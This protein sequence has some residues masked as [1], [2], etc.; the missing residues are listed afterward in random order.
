[1]RAMIFGTGSI[2]RRHVASLRAIDPGAEFLI[3]RRSGE[4]DDFSRRLGAQVVRTAVEGIDAGIDLAV[5]ATPSDL[6]F[7]PL[8]AA[9]AAGIPTFVEK[10]VVISHGDLDVLERVAET[11]LVP[12]QVGCVLRFLP[13]SSVLKQWLDEGRAGKVVRATFDVGQYLPDWRPHQDYRTSY[14]ADSKRGGGVIFDLVHELDLAVYLFGD[15]RLAAAIA[16][17]NSR[18]ELA[19]EDTAL[20]ALRAQD[21]ILVSVALDYVSR[22]PTRSIRI[23]GD[24]ATLSLDFIRCRLE[25]ITAG[26]ITDAITYGFETDLAYQAELMDLIAAIRAG[27]AT[28]LPLRE[29]LRSTRL[30]IEARELAGI[31]PNLGGS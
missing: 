17:R 18:L 14:S 30:S 9:L 1:M 23:I 8:T 29:G 3:V 10:P 26:G 4:S 15:C 6:H 11:T 19:C 7:E 21:G 28:R 5:I 12:T 16:A 13:A 2:G 20:L 25:R 27:T 31:S 22:A 24:E